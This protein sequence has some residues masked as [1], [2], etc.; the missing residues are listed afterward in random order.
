MAIAGGMTTAYNVSVKNNELRINQ[1]TF[2]SDLCMAPGDA[3]VEV[4]RG[5]QVTIK[6]SDVVKFQKLWRESVAS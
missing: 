4:E 2:P 1:C 5:N 6:G 3:V